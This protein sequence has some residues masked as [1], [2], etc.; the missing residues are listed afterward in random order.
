MLPRK[1]EKWVISV[2]GIGMF[3]STLDSGIIN[4]ALPSLQE[5]FHSPLTTIS[6]TI[7]A[8]LL[9]L[10]STIIVFGK[11][12]DRYGRLRLF[13]LGLVIFAVSSV[14][15]GL[16]LSAG[17]L[18]AFRSVQ[19]LGAAILQATAIALVTTLIAQARHGTALG[20][21]SAIMAV[22]PIVG[23]TVAGLLLSIA[24]WRWLFWINL[25]LC[26]LALWGCSNLE[27]TCEVSQQPFNLAA[28]LLLSF[29]LFCSILTLT[30]LHPLKVEAPQLLIALTVLII[31]SSYLFLIWQRST[32]HP[33][34]PIAVFYN[35][36][37]LSAVLSTFGFG[38]ATAIV[39][40][41]PPLL[42]EHLGQLSPWQIGL[43]SFCMPLGAVTSARF[44][45]RS[46]QHLGGYRLMLV[47]LLIMMA[48]L[49][50][51]ALIQYRM[52]PLFFALL[53]FIYG[54]GCGFFQPPSIAAITGAVTP[55]EQGTASAVNRMTHN[56]GNAVGVAISAN[57][58]QLLSNAA[59]SNLEQEFFYS[60]L[61]ALAFIIF[62]LIFSIRLKNPSIGKTF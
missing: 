36:D 38:A 28:N 57:S 7:S 50:G 45:G 26:T 22:G 48:S 6:W 58:L 37:F 29:T 62:S 46:I 25:P 31:V 56:F 5:Q 4:V 9:V 8:Y 33:V 55:S 40:M 39:L 53:L 47:G 27:D 1:Q 32:D 13:K 17:Y 41:L 11:L 23:P 35:R 43:A 61:F 12:S 18:I 20:M 10:S 34:L 49:L 21:L 14:L 3:L 52:G 19:G 60:W 44:S 24:D 54:C 59:A 16:S 2:A 42:L 30:F 15:C 51:L